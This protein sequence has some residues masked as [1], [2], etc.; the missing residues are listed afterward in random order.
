M[1]SS[2]RTW[3]HSPLEQYA[4]DDLR[5]TLRFGKRRVQPAAERWRLKRAAKG[6]RCAYFTVPDTT[7]PQ[8]TNERLVS[9]RN[10]DCVVWRSAWNKSSP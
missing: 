3:R 8:F 10:V 7:V 6:W 1:A 9:I 4:I 5:I 2:R